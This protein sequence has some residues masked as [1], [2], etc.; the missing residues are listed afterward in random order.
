MVKSSL[1]GGPDVPD[2][3]LDPTNPLDFGTPPL[4]ITR[5]LRFARKA[6]F[7]K[8]AYFA[9]DQAATDGATAL[10]LDDIEKEVKALQGR[11]YKAHR[12]VPASAD[13]DGVIGSSLGALALS[14]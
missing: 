14:K 7:F 12:Y 11:T 6:H 2:R 9:L 4:Q 10:R 3:A 1:R 5:V 13:S 8:I